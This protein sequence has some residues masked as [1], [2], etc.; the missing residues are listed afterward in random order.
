[1]KLPALF[2]FYLICAFFSQS[3]T[4][5]NAQ[6][7]REYIT[8]LR[9]VLTE[10]NVKNA[11][12]LLKKGTGQATLNNA[13]VC[14]ISGKAFIILDFG[15]EMHGGIQIVTGMPSSQTPIPLRLCFGE[16][17]AEA[18][19][20]IGEK[21]ATN[22]HGM[23]DYTV[24]VP[25][26]GA[27]E[28]GNTGF[29][30]LKIELKDTSR[31]LQ[32]REV[33]GISVTH[34]APVLG[35]FYCSDSTLTKIWQTGVKT[36]HLCMQ[37]YIWDG[38]K[39]DRLV[40]VGDMFPEMMTVLSTFGAVDVIPKSLDISR[41]SNPLP[42]WMNGIS[43]YSLWWI[44]LHDKWYS[45]TSDTVYLY[46]QKDYLFALLKQIMGKIDSRGREHLDGTRFLDW[47]S[48]ANTDAV[49]AGLQALCC[50]VFERSE[51]LCRT[52]G[53]EPLAMECKKMHSKMLSTAKKTAVDFLK[54]NKNPLGEKQAVALLYLSGA[55]DSQTAVAVLEKDGAKDFSTFYGYFMI[56]ALAKA[57]HYQQAMDIIKEYWGGML[58]MGASTFWE[59]FDTE[60]MDGS[61]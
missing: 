28:T 31:T 9:V 35:D 25:W 46:E 1:M 34:P 48:N 15:S 47:P 61:A 58:A 13:D 29:R 37:D 4:A 3:A 14:S 18:M 59:D 30:F 17:V 32:L 55:M 19:S 43:S 8:P 50:I 11:E 40:W 39:R 27:I 56:E 44:L 7:Q 42:G 10:G 26:L 5:Q 57:G 41:Q 36:V 20:Q 54:K 60:W 22:D 24:T 45:Y 51:D 52:L 16:S 33:R 23:R 53:N 12:H 21:G 49:D 6:M 2:S 38:I